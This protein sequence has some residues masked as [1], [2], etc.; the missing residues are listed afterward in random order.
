MH[1]DQPAMR[2]RERLGP[3]RA[4]DPSLDHPEPP[5]AVIASIAWP[6]GRLVR[7]ARPQRPEEQRI[8]EPCPVRV[9][10][11]EIQVRLE[12]PG[13]C[14]DASGAASITIARIAAWSCPAAPDQAPAPALPC[15]RSGSRASAS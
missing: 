5:S 3:L 1:H 4:D 6:H 9:L 10:D 15:C 12:H 2:L 14:R 11:A 7:Q 13:Q 8:E